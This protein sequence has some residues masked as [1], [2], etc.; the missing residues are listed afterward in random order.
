MFKQPPLAFLLAGSPTPC[1]QQDFL[2]SSLKILEMWMPYLP[3]VSKMQNWNT[4]ESVL[5]ACQLCIT[6]K[7]ATTL[8]SMYDQKPKA[9]E[10]YNMRIKYHSNIVQV[11][12][13]SYNTI[14]NSITSW[15]PM[16]FKQK[17]LWVQENWIPSFLLLRD[18]AVIDLVAIICY[19]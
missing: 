4:P 13:T 8:Y 17:I 6:R 18:A 1:R 15:T 12:S 3:N 11:Y 5:L 19:C 9:S 10:K 16:I 14:E 7:Y 2:P